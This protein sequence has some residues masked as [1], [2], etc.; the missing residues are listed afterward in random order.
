MEYVCKIERVFRT[1]VDKATW[2][3]YVAKHMLNWKDPIDGIESPILIPVVI[4]NHLPKPISKSEW[5]HIWCL[6][7][8]LQTSIWKSLVIQTVNTCDQS[9]NH[10]ARYV[11]PKCG[12]SAHSHVS[13]KNKRIVINIPE[14]CGLSCY[15]LSTRLFSSVL[16]NSFI[17][18][19]QTC[20]KKVQQQK[21]TN[22][23][24]IACNMI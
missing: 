21:S 23:S 24:H 3:M 9:S 16:N 19:F 15:K 12:I 22:M 14:F 11:C 10:M 18:N 17:E 6:V 8:G 20:S 1:T 13:Y 7:C 2:R 5:V 4:N